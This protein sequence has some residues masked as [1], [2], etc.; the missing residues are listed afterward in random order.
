MESSEFVLFRKKLKK[1]QT[2][3]AQLLGISAKA[4]HSYEQGWRSVPTH[5]ERQMLFLVTR[6]NRDKKK[7]SCWDINKCPDDRKEKCPAWEFKVG[8]LCWFINGTICEGN[9]Q[10]NWSEKIKV[11]KSCEA[12][13]P[14]LK[15]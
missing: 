4:V 10:K 1:T 5:V 9:V 2:Q 15:A 7:K 13:A 11:C 8:D 14:E 3:I 6:I 12:L